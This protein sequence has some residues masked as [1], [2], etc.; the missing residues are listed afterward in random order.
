MIFYQGID[1]WPEQWE[2]W[3]VDSCKETGGHKVTYQDHSVSWEGE[4]RGVLWMPKDEMRH[5]WE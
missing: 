2:I 1:S 3:W 4:I 5:M